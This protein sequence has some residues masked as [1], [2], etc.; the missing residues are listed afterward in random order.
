MAAGGAAR[1]NALHRNRGEPHFSARTRPVFDGGDDTL[2]ECRFIAA[3]LLLGVS[4][5]L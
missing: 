3:K 4:F 5:W 1:A 2:A